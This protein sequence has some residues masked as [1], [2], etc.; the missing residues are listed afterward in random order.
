VRRV[1]IAAALAV[2]AMVAI[3]AWQ[4]WQ[5]L[6]ATPF[7]VGIDGYFYAIQVRS[8]LEHGTLAYAASP[9]AFW[10][11]V[12]FTLAA[13]GDPIVGAKLGAAIGCALIAVPMYFTGKRLGGGSRGAGLV[14]AALATASAGSAYLTFEF[15]K[16]GLGLLGTVSVNATCIAQPHGTADGARDGLNWR[17]FAALGVVALATLLTHKLAF[18]LLVVLAAPPLIVRV[19]RS[20]F[21]RRR[22]YAVLF[23]IIAVVALAIAGVAMPR[24]MP[25]LIDLDLVRGL[26]AAPHW[27]PVHVGGLALNL[28]AIPVLAVSH[29]HLWFRHEPL[30]AGVL[31]IGAAVVVVRTDDPVRRA[32]GWAVVAV[33]LFIAQPWLAVDDPQGLGFRLRI[34]AFVPMSLAAAI[35]AGALPI[36]RREAVL[37][38]LAAAMFALGASRSLTEGEVEMHPALAAAAAAAAGKIPP[39]ATVIVPER[40]ILYAV[41]WYTRAPV[42]LRP[43]AVPYA[44]RARIFGLAFAGGAGSPMDQAIDE[45]RL[46]PTI[47]PPI[48]LHPT[49]RNGLVLVS[50]PTWEWLL[51]HVPPDTRAYFARWPTI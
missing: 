13:G 36:P 11:M 20:L 28:P 35:V 40:H 9:L 8:L 45:A 46:D 37:A 32:A 7:P 38:V 39:G 48:G 22:I 29:A 2:S 5:I 12:P 19:R 41:Q 49:D 1:S 18:A 16:Q 14:A 51:A 17:T 31:S 24:R 10:W 3:S 47:A 30:I 50:E 4:R 23:G 26:F 44:S 15:V 33:G 21:G 27:S 43:D 42:S 6:D 34:A 25:S